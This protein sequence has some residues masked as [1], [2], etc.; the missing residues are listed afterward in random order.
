MTWCRQTA[1]SD[2]AAAVELR[3]GLRDHSGQDNIPSKG[4]Q[5]IC[6]PGACLSRNVHCTVATAEQAPALDRQACA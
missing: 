1:A 4:C 6:I 2:I 3:R 5:T